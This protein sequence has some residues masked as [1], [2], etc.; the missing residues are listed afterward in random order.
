[1]SKH[2]LLVN[3]KTLTPHISRRC[4]LSLLLLLLAVPF[5]SATAQAKPVNG[6]T[7]RIVGGVDA[8]PS[9]YPWIAALL[10]SNN[11]NAF[12]SQFCAGSLIGDRWILTAAH[13]VNGFTSASEIEVAIGIADLRNISSSDR[14]PVISI[15]V[16]PD[17]DDI[18]SDNDIAL[19]KLAT[20]SSN[21]VLAIADN[22]LTNSIPVDGTV[23]ADQMTIIGWGD[24][25]ASSTPPATSVFPRLLQEASIPKFDFATCN[26]IYNNALTSNMICAG[27]AAGGNDTCQGDS[28]GPLLYFNPADSSWYQT[29]VTSFGNGCALANNPGIYTRAA[30]YI[31]WVNSTM[32]ISFPNRYRFG[33]HGVGRPSAIETLTLRNFSGTAITV[34]AVT[35]SNPTNFTLVSDN[36]STAG[37]IADGGSCTVSLQF[38]A[39]GAGSQLATLTV[40]FGTGNPS[41]NTTVSGF[42]LA[43]INA[44]ALDET[45][46]R[47]WYSGGDARWRTTT[48]ANSNGGTAMRNGNIDDNKGSAI[49][50]YFTGPTTL[51]FRWKAS[52]EQDFDL[53][54]LYVDNRLIDSISGNKDW[55]QRNIALGAGEHRVVWVYKKDSPVSSLSDTVWLDSIN[56]PFSGNTG[57]TGSTTTNGGF[58]K[59][60]GGG[61]ST[62]FLLLLIVTLMFQHRLYYRHKASKVNR[63]PTENE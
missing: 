6:V 35:F 16:H 14:I 7:P 49:L 60:G 43:T 52:T 12:S 34:S 5:F 11:A 8:S 30:N 55:L 15:L 27:F 59:S 38:Q 17:Y 40:D 21:T 37:S 45:P 28:G 57:N 39:T 20:P 23:T 36:C 3:V 44:A 26:S 51:G 48:I 46:A 13:C 29:G 1:M 50:S 47:N 41:L 31:V 32:A 19:L 62:L 25:T 4:G 9:A 61:I 2:P 22:T 58:G 42:G 10:R 24:T 56:T 53:L 18:S 63:Q 54:K 33:Y